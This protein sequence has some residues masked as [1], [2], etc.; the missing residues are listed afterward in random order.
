LEHSCQAD[1]D[2]VAGVL[3][4]IGHYR[5][6]SRLKDWHRLVEEAVQRFPDNSA[7]LLQAT[8]AAMARKAYKK[9]AGFA[10]RLLKIDPINPGV[11]RQMIEL[12]VAHAR[13]QMRVGRLELA[14]KEL[15]AAAEWERPDAPNALLRIAH[16]L[17]DLHA[18]QNEQAQ[19]RLREGVALAGGGVAGWFRAAMEGELMKFTGGSAGL[20]RHELAHARETPPTKEAVMAIVSALG[21]P[22]ASENKRAVASLLLGMRAWLLQ[23]AAIDWPPA[24]FQA[25]AEMLARFDAFDLLAEYARAARRREPGNPIWRFHEIIARTRGDT[26]KLTMGEM[27]E[28]DRMADA[29]GSREDFH[30][31]NRIERFLNGV[32]HTPSGR[33][34]SAAALPDMLDDNDFLG[35]VAA[36]VEDMPKGSADSVRGLVRDFGREGAVAHMFQQLRSTPGGPGM[37]DLVL[38]EMCQVMVAKAMDSRRSGQP[39][40]ARRSRF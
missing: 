28:L 8:E 2:Y 23:A 30:E 27:E 32:S 22:D 4:L 10:H 31:A 26:G 20:L 40:T 29:A 25:L 5:A 37:P 18:G 6:E 11:R 33:R 13:K 35:L 34:R 17:V 12:Q 38:R 24:E 16:G 21:Q 15:A 36:M 14:A 39:A 7:V 9:A 19:E 1:P 3:K